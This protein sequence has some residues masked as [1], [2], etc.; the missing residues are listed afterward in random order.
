MLRSV[1]KVATR[2]G[3]LWPVC[4]Q[5]LKTK[6]VNILIGNKSFDQNFLENR[7]SAKNRETI[8]KKSAKL[9]NI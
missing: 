2:V 3:V 9:S 4:Y 7:E 8:G 1:T 6:D 5:K